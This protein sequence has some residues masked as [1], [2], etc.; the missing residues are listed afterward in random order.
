MRLLPFYP[1][2]IASSCAGLLVSCSSRG[3]T[4]NAENVLSHNDFESLEG[5]IPSNPSLTTAKAHSGR[6]SIMVDNNV[7]YSMSYTSIVGKVS[8]MR[9]KKL[10][11]S[12]WAL[13]TD[14]G[15]EAQL[16]VEVKNPADSEQKIFWESIT[17]GKEVK[18]INQWTQIKKT[19]VLP[20][21]VEPTHELRVYMWRGGATPPV[22]LDDV[23]ISRA[24]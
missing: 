4:A 11:L 16:V 12:A 10:G 21:S 14:Q 8:P 9:I 7:E 23:I 24:D 19:F 18:G 6:H 2:L 20:E 15:S 17:L 22:F 5:W 13:V 1:L 3:T